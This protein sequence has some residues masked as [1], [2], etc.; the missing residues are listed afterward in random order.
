M[1]E[2]TFNVNVKK[3]TSGSVV[4]FD[5]S[6]Q[7][8]FVSY[9]VSDLNI[10]VVP[11]PGIAAGYVAQIALPALTAGRAYYVNVTSGVFTTFAGHAWV[12]SDPST[13]SFT[14]NG[15]PDPALLSLAS[16]PTDPWGARPFVDNV[17]LTMTFDEVMQVCVH[18]RA[19]CF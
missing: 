8:I 2:L 10:T 6:K 17:T 13:W 3:G 9:N 1:L 12:G 14:T 16:Q 15:G 19:G 11:S 5:R 7:Q 4:V 18:C